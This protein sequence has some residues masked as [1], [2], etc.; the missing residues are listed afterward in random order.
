MTKLRNMTATVQSNEEAGL[1]TLMSTTPKP[2]RAVTMERE[3]SR[4]EQDADQK[5]GNAA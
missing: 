5:F 2:A 4:Q 3:D 1:R